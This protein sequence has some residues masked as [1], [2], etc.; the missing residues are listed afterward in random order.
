MQFYTHVGTVV[1][2][3]AK[4]DK[5]VD[6]RAG[7]AKAA[8]QDLRATLKAKGLAPEVNARAV[9]A[10]VVSRLAYN[11][12]TWSGAS[13]R[14]NATLRKV[15]AHAARLILGKFREGRPLG[16]N[17]EVIKEAGLEDIVPILARAKINVLK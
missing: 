1:Q 15:I 3:G 11:G 10:M 16:K 9:K 13:R 6:Q 5:E 4:L 12:G 17:R 7:K 8:L 2:A 14:H